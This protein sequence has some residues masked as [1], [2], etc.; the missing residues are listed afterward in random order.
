VYTLGEAARASG[1]SKPTIAKATGRL[2]AA[3]SEDGTYQIDEA[4]L[5][6]V[7]PMTGQ[8]NS[9]LLRSLTP[10]ETGFTGVNPAT[11]AASELSGRRSRSNGKR[12]FAIC[13]PGSILRPRNAVG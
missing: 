3:R 1:K 4:E 6:R 8:V 13:A 12:R 11:A 2:S 5:H 10:G 7:Y 9:H